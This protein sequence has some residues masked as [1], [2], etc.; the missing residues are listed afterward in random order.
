VNRMQGIIS[1]ATAGG[2]GRF[3]N[4]ETH[5]IAVFEQWM[6]VVYHS[7]GLTAGFGVNPGSGGEDLAGGETNLTIGAAP[8]SRQEGPPPTSAATVAAA[9]P[10]CRAACHP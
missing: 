5:Q 4:D 9:A 10:H 7:R 2:D 8:W 3:W 1:D 6:V